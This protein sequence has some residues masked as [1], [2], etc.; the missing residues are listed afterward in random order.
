MLFSNLFN[1]NSANQKSKEVGYPLRQIDY[2]ILRSVRRLLSELS[3]FG[4]NINI[5]FYAF[6]SFSETPLTLRKNFFDALKSCNRILIISNKSIFN[7]DNENYFRDLATL[8]GDTHCYYRKY[9]PL[10]SDSYLSKHSSHFYVRREIR[11]W[12]TYKFSLWCNL[13]ILLLL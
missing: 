3:K 11:W 2:W 8:L 4:S 7:I 1:S 6:W 9:L 12:A 10:S 13:L 5:D